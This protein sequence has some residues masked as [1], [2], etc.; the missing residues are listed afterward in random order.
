LTI[1]PVIAGS[2]GSSSRAIV[3]TSSAAP[4]VIVPSLTRVTLL[5]P[6]PPTEC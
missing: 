1:S 4:Q 2:L 5:Q 3:A 6:V